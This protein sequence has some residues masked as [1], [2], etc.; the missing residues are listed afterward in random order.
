MICEPWIEDSDLTLCGATLSAFSSDAIE[1]ALWSASE[2]LY[3]LTQQQYPGECSEQVRPCGPVGAPIGWPLTSSR[4]PF[5]PFEIGGQI[6]NMTCGGCHWKV[7]GCGGYPAVDL[8]RSD[9][10]DVVSVQI[11]ATVVASS[12]Y[13]LDSSRWLVRT[14]GQAWPCCQDMTADPGEEGSFVITIEYGDPV[15][16]ALKTA[17]ASYASELLKACGSDADRKACRLP[18]RLQSVTRQGITEAFAIVLTE[19][20]V[21]LPDVDSVIA[22]WNPTRRA[23]LSG[24]YSPETSPASVRVPL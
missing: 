4:L 14:D 9:V 5:R 2:T 22:A 6:W 24:V 17:A 7:C 3:M 1:N 15:P 11:G 18:I 12:S 20:G 19:G 13:R 16:Q 23:V 21:G 10:T 8:G